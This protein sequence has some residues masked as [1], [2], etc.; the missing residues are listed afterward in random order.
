MAVAAATAPDVSERC[1]VRASEPDASC[2][3][4]GF[5]SAGFDAEALPA[6]QVDAVDESQVSLAPIGLSLAVMGGTWAVGA[7]ALEEGV[8]AYALGAG[9]AA[10][11]VTYLVAALLAG[12]L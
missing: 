7:G 4:I 9:V 6:T 3:S 2:E 10:G 12:G 11:V 8:P 5:Y 1:L